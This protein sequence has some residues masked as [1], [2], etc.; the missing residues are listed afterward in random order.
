MDKPEVTVL[1]MAAQRSD[2]IIIEINP[3]KHD[4]LTQLP[5]ERLMG[6]QNSL[7]NAVEG[8][9]RL[10]L[11]AFWRL[12]LQENPTLNRTASVK[13]YRDTLSS[14]PENQNHNLIEREL[15]YECRTKPASIA[16]R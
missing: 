7:L 5:P 8:D 10:R 2:G 11:E 1:T 12:W 6:L 4:S 16:A 9:Q 3:I 14:L 15:V 13:F